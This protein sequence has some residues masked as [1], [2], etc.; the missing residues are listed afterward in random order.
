MNIFVDANILLNL[1]E[2]RGDDIED[3]RALNDLSASNIYK[4]HTT[5]VV[6]DEF[7]RNRDRVIA[8]AIK[9]F[10]TAK[11]EIQYPSLVRTLDGYGDLRALHSKLKEHHAS[12]I[13][14]IR[15]KISKED[16]DIDKEISRHFSLCKTLKSSNGVVDAAV[17]RERLGKDPGKPGHLGDHINWILLINECRASGD[18]IIVSGDGDY[19]SRL[20]PGN[21][22]TSLSEEY[23]SGD[24]NAKLATSLKSVVKDF[25]TMVETHESKDRSAAIEALRDSGSFAE[26]HS[27][28]A[29]LAGFATYT[30]QD[31][32]TLVDIAKENG[33][34]G[35]I[36]SDEDVEEFYI[37]LRNKAIGNKDELETMRKKLDDF[38][39]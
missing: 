8:D 16:L 23:K 20:N 28:I 31:V 7:R 17:H 21:I 6:I 14:A 5:D 3:L 4:M 11:I 27:V 19:E 26:T 35:S 1:Y 22:R 33:Q 24:H 36:V 34:V 13:K 9:A 18:V 2:I 30:V 10:E 29:R 25:S 38:L 32:G 12:A 37:S 15:E 39:I